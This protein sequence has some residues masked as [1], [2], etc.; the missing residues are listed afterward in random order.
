[1][2]LYLRFLIFEYFEEQKYN[3]EFIGYS[4]P[5]KYIQED[6]N[7]NTLL[8]NLL[9]LFV[10]FL[11]EQFYDENLLKKGVYAENFIGLI[12]FVLDVG[13][14]VLNWKSD[15]NNSLAPI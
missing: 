4:L 10:V 8:L 3:R 2:V 6:G 1:M 7:Y 14:K 11:C 12:P 9:N 15:F 13:L 5:E